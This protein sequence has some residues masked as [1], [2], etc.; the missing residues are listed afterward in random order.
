MRLRVSPR[1]GVVRFG[2]EGKLALRC[3]GPFE[4]YEKDLICGIPVE[5]S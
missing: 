3:V 2:K 1:K 5:I 4:I